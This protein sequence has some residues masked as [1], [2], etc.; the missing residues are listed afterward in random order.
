[1]SSKMGKGEVEKYF[2]QKLNEV[3]FKDPPPRVREQAD[4]TR[5]KENV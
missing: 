4:I 3:M 1:M 5:R 2:A